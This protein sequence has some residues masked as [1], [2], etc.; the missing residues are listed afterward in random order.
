MS[1]YI[2]TVLD[3]TDIQDY[4]FG[5]NV[6]RENIGASELVRRATR[7][8]PFEEVRKV[9]KTNV[10][11]DRSL[12][13]DPGDLDGNLHINDHNLDAEVIYAGGGNCVILFANKDTARN[14]VTELSRRVLAQAPG[15]DL[16]RQKEGQVGHTRGVQ[17]ALKGKV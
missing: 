4:I 13:G 3:T 16:W 6:L 11:P 10:K 1:M 15:L 9:G 8:W 2:L 12:S 17:I 14:V 7:L 5:S